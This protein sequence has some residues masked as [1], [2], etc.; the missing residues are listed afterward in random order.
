MGSHRTGCDKTRQ[1]RHRYRRHPRR[2]K[3]GRI[4]LVRRQVRFR[5]LRALWDPVTFMWTHA[6]TRYCQP[7]RE[8]EWCG[9][10][11]PGYMT[12]DSYQKGEPKA[13]GCPNHRRLYLAGPRATPNS[14]PSKTK[15]IAAEQLTQIRNIFLSDGKRKS[16]RRWRP[17]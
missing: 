16:S 10:K 4:H 17:S 1:H 3:P 9:S 2:Q 14:K 8:Y 7:C 12:T 13:A 11:A 15:N 5:N 6:M